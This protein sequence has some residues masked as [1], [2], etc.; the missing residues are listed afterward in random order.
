MKI[1][2]K[3]IELVK[4]ILNIDNEVFIK[5]VTDFINNENADFW[6][7]MSAVEQAEIKKGIEQLD[8]GNRS[9]HKDVLNRI[10]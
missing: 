2:T 9:L 6:N 4:L 3:K 8:K 1:E 5:K 7:E 10:S